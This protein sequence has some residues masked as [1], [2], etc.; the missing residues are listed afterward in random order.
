VG[1]RLAEET[2]P[3][4]WESLRVG[5]WRQ[6]EG[7]GR[8]QEAFASDPEG[9]AAAK[10]NQWLALDQGLGGEA[11]RNQVQAWDASDL[12]TRF[13]MA[14]QLL[15][16]N[17]DQGMRLLRDLVADGSV[18]PIDLATW[19]LFDRLRDEGRLADINGQSAGRKRR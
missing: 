11:I 7:L 13:E 2:W 5:R 4:I 12:P 19:P 8:L 3:A 18:K 1:T 6:A 15:L 9:V 16:R 17:D 14:R 10:V